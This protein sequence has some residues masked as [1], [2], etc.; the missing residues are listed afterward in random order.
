[1][2]KAKKARADNEVDKVEVAREGTV[3][4]RLMLL[5]PLSTPVPPA[6]HFTRLKHKLKHTLPLRYRGIY[7]A[8]CKRVQDS[9]PLA[10]PKSR[11]CSN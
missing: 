5:Q 9:P 2:R 1:M 6:G 8:G 10:R 11:A 7:A 4:I 3:T